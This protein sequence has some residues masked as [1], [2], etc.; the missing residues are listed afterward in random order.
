MPKNPDRPKLKRKKKIGRGPGRPPRAPLTADGAVQRAVA[1]VETRH[2]IS[3]KVVSEALLKS[4]GLL[5]MAAHALDMPRA[6]LVRYIDRHEVCMETLHAAR[7]GMGDV[8]EAKLFEL[9]EE[10]DVR[11]ILYYLST[12][13]RGRGYGTR[14]EEDPAGSN[15]RGPVFVETVNIVGVPSGTFLPK[16]VATKD[17]MVIDN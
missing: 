2:H 17:S 12:V 8:A 11:C 4:H 9:I 7:E 15:G 5:K 16:D 14:N 10:G 3:P 13:H 1:K 6:T